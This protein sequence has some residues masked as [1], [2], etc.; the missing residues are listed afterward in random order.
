MPGGIAKTATLALGL[1][2][3]LL[4]PT[5]G[6]HAAP[7][8]PL[9]IAVVGS[10]ADGERLA[11]AANGAR[12]AAAAAGKKG[13]LAAGVTVES[14]DAGTDKKA[15]QTTL[16]KA[17]TKKPALVIAVPPD[18]MHPIYWK[19]ARSLR[20]PWVTVA[21]MAPDSVRNPGNLLHLGPTPV[22]Q[23]VIAA[24]AATAP[25]AARRVAAVHEPTEYGRT[26]ASTFARNLSSRI[27]L[28]GVQEWGPDA[29]E[30]T[31]GGLKAFEAEWIYVAM[32]GSH[33]RRF[34]KTLAASGWRPKL[35]FADG[36]RDESLLA[37]G[38]EALEGCVFLDGP[39]P[40]LH[41]RL[42]ER[43][44]DDL[45][46]ADQPLDVV[47]VRAYEGV[48]RLLGAMVKAAATK[49]KKVWA[50]LEPEIPAPGTLGTISFEHHGAIRM[51]PMTFWRVKDGA[52]EMW[53]RG[54]LPTEG[55]GPPIGFGRP[56][57]ATYNTKGKLGF[58]TYGEG[59]KRT[60]EQ[61]L[62]ECGLITKGKESDLDKIVL[63]EVMN[64]AIRIANRL[65]RREADGSPIPGWSWGMA[66]T[67]A[68]P[69][70]DVKR[71]A[72]WLARIAGDHEAAG[73][74]AFGTWVAVYST[75]LKRTMYAA[76]KLD[77]P[78]SA[79]D[80]HLL[81]GTYRWGEDRSANFRADKIRCLMDGFASAIGLT[82][83][84]EYGH[85][86]GCGHDTEHPTS[87]MNVV[88]GAGASWEDAVWIP[89]HQR[90]VT[91][92]LGIEAVPK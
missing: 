61:D 9:V 28:A 71:G 88:A 4:L 11:S 38:R 12:I 78:I 82:L 22:G 40:E 44:I 50:A 64:R 13:P 91:T 65:F 63:E 5:A 2:L 33:A 89:R 34:V 79:K 83:S 43:L 60:I 49:L 20:V 81:D 24:D 75:F 1:G 90:N 62:Y 55:C 54:L 30:E 52:Y 35:F 73:G 16:R 74:Q 76:R 32:N 23:A 31:L 18:D 87:I 6:L 10:L 47:T 56:K 8:K 42:G 46:R 57:T 19:A 92:T 77:P 21:G 84:H 27:T 66:F 25:L 14:V 45:E 29:G 15:F 53:P 72:I 3:G 68:P 51:L 58:L 59:E 48:R 36:A 70:D 39:D 69:G 67:T 37:L 86:C 26:L 41:G 7:K 80:R 85:L 17:R